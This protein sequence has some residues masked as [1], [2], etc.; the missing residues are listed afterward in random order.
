MARYVYCMYDT[1]IKHRFGGECG[2]RGHIVDTYSTWV[3]NRSNTW[4]MYCSTI[5]I[6]ERYSFTSTYR[7]RFHFHR[8]CPVQ[9]NR[10]K[11]KQQQQKLRRAENEER[12]HYRNILLS[13][14]VKQQIKKINVR[15]IM[16]CVSHTLWFHCSIHPP[17]TWF[18]SW[19]L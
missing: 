16:V 17:C 2:S 15:A 14:P 18:T 6:W 19:N 4:W 5:Q 10:G 13:L 9:N 1:Y 11:P 3:T 8:L 12:N 7:S